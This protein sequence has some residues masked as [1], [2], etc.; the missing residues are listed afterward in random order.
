VSCTVIRVAHRVAHQVAQQ[1]FAQGRIALHQHLGAPVEGEVQP[2][3]Q[4]FRRK[5]HADPLQQ[6]G[7]VEDLDR[8]LHRVGIEP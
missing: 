2:L 4:G 5:L 3:L 8:R 1:P 6:Q 7:D